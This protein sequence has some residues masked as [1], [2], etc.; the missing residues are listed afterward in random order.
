MIKAFM[1][2]NFPSNFKFPSHFDL[3]KVHEE[4]SRSRFIN[5][6]DHPSGQLFG[7]VAQKIPAWK[8]NGA[9]WSQCGQIPK[10]GDHNNLLVRNIPLWHSDTCSYEVR[11]LSMEGM[12]AFKELDVGFLF[13][14]GA[15]PGPL[16]FWAGSRWADKTWVDTHTTPIEV[17]WMVGR[18]QNQD[19]ND[20][21]RVALPPTP[22][23]AHPATPSTIKDESTTNIGIG[24][25]PPITS[26]LSIP[27][28]QETDLSMEDSRSAKKRS[29][30]AISAPTPD[31]RPIASIT[32]GPPRINLDDWEP[33]PDTL[34]GRVLSRAATRR[35]RSMRNMAI[36]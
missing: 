11:R 15:V 33:G 9:N 18:Y 13:T 14:E 4:L 1:E 31:P 19:F 29:R 30:S 5:Y 27:V 7:S 23:P 12:T 24:R 26:N 22:L 16:S 17:T 8:A 3:N 28:E 36:T 6:T 21:W 2:C 35:R 34:F 32:S 25:G 20:L 10:F